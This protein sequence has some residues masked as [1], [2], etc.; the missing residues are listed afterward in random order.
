M[1]ILKFIYLTA[2]QAYYNRACA[3]DPLHPDLPKIVLK[4]KE[5]EDEAR[6]M[7]V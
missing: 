2:A 5:L 3:H 4:R 7:W 1:K 6:R